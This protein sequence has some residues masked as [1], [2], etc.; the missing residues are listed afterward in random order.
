MTIMGNWSFWSFTNASATLQL[1]GNLTFMQSFRGLAGQIDPVVDITGQ[2]ITGPCPEN[3][4]GEA[5]GLTFSANGNTFARRI[6]HRLRLRPAPGNDTT[7]GGTI[8]VQG[9][10]W[11]A[12]LQSQGGIT[13][14]YVSGDQSRWGRAGGCLYFGGTGNNYSGLTTINLNADGCVDFASAA[15]TPAAGV[16]ADLSGVTSINFN[17]GTLQL[18]GEYNDFAAM[19]GGFNVVSGTLWVATNDSLGTAANIIQLG[20]PNSLGMLTGYTYDEGDHAITHNI[21]LNGQGGVIRAYQDGSIW[22][23]DRSGVWTD[24]MFNQFN[25]ASTISGSG[26]LIKIGNVDTELENGTAITFTPNTYGNT[27]VAGTG[28]LIIDTNRSVGTGNV[29]VCAGGELSVYGANAFS[30]MAPGK[31]VLLEGGVPGS[32]SILDVLDPNVAPCWTRIATASWPWAATSAWATAARSPSNWPP[33][34][35]ATAPTDSCSWAALPHGA[36]PA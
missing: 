23:Y 16:T 2:V 1:G 19:P 31:T 28:R 18:E 5:G 27:V 13:S 11:L 36:A 10:D 8:T 9:T 17:G 12:S 3:P 15:N 6:Q 25:I 26:A 20:G 35:K 34:S 29:T 21:V 22:I 33:E 30:S 32:P 4:T 7:V 24:D 14:V